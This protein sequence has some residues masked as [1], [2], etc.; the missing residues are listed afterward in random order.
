MVA[1]LPSRFLEGDHED[2]EARKRDNGLRDRQTSPHAFRVTI[3]NFAQRLKSTMVFFPHEVLAFSS[4]MYQLN[5]MRLIV[6]N[7]RS[8]FLGTSHLTNTGAVTGKLRTGI[9]VFEI[10]VLR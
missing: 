7:V 2:P 3:L 4:I 8:H 5:E 1:R 9:S 6:R 10:A